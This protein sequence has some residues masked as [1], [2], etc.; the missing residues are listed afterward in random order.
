[1]SAHTPYTPSIG[2]TT[3]RVQRQRI[4]L[5]RDQRALPLLATSKLVDDHR[6]TNRVVG[7]YALEVIYSGRRSCYYGR[8]RPFTT[9]GAA[10]A[11]PETCFR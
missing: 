1:M 6:A 5:H 10:V 11:V 8:V 7:Q 2:V 9:Y 4:A 3:A